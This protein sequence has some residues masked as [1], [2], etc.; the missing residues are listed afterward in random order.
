MSIPFFVSVFLVDAEGRTIEKIQDFTKWVGIMPRIGEHIFL[1]PT[2]YKVTALTH[3][4]NEHWHGVQI[5]VRKSEI[6]TKYITRDLRRGDF[7]TE[8][9]AVH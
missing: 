5:F 9:I 3:F 1:E 4:P 2:I 8:S 6:D 7:P